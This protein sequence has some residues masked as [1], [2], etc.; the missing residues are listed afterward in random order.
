M[1]R[2]PHVL[3]ALAAV[4]AWSAIA[5]WTAAFAIPGGRG[6]DAEAM[7]AFTGAASAPRAPSIEGLAVLA[8]PVPFLLG[9]VLLVGLALLRRRPFMAAMV[10][11]IL[12]VANACTQVLKPALADPRIIDLGGTS[13]AGGIYPGSWPSG[14][15]TAS[16]SLALCFVLVVGPRLRPAAALLGAAYAIGVGYS[17]VAAG[18][19]LPSDVLGGYLVAATFTLVGAGAL[20]AFETRRPAPAPRVTW[21]ARMPSWAS[22]APAAACAAGLALLGTLAV[23]AVLI[24]RPDLAIGSLRHVEALVVAVGIGA[25]GLGL[26]AGLAFALRR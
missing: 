3:L 7:Q 14:H 25:L 9:G 6:L 21:A 26:T 10:P 18:W 23:L 15:A 13:G 1:S 19:H 20:A 2:R 24:R 22:P 16:M 5:V 4:S 8:N 17:L 12:L 11:V